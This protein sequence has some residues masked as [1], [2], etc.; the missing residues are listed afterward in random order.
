MNLLKDHSLSLLHDLFKSSDSFHKVG[1]CRCKGLL[2]CSSVLHKQFNNQILLH[3]LKTGENLELQNSTVT[4]TSLWHTGYK[5]S[6]S[7]F[8]FF[9]FSAIADHSRQLPLTS[10]WDHTDNILMSHLNKGIP[11]LEKSLIEILNSEPTTHFSSAPLCHS[12]HTVAAVRRAQPALLAR[13]PQ[14][15]R[16]TWGHRSSSPAGGGCFQWAA[17]H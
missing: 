4:H 3:C 6:D 16:G 9:F 8:F 17:R 7:L 15:A 13:W 11:H 2:S 5:D 1:N 10:G 12:L 14:A